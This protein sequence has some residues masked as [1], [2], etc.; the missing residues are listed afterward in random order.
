MNKLVNHIN[1]EICQKCP[2]HGE[3][4]TL[5]NILNNS[6]TFYIDLNNKTEF[7]KYLS[8][9]IKE[10]RSISIYESNHATFL[11]KLLEAEFNF[12]TV[13]YYILDI[14]YKAWRHSI[15]S[16]TDLLKYN[17]IVQTRYNRPCSQFKEIVSNILN[18]HKE[19][20]DTEINQILN[21]TKNDL[22]K[23]IIECF[24][25]VHNKLFNKFKSIILSFN[26]P[27]NLTD[28]L[29]Y[30]SRYTDT[31]IQSMELTTVEIA[32]INRI[33]VDN[34]VYV[35]AEVVNWKLEKDFDLIKNIIEVT[36]VPVYDI[37]Y[38]E[39]GLERTRYLFQDY[40]T[41]TA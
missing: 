32:S 4:N 24:L 23:K 7:E 1:A 13:T 35:T 28:S 21:Y 16:I 27:R 34:K 3:C 38:A 19:E 36:N 9:S 8:L 39:K 12:D 37:I 20:Y 30:L 33:L 10:S 26:I 40:I 18:Y 29:F 6:E 15:S 5:Q 31:L 11:S 14:K 41:K 17:C 22:S 2:L 25:S